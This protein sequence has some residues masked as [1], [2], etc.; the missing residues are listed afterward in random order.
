MNNEPIRV[1]SLEAIS[2]L[3]HEPVENL[4]EF[5]WFVQFG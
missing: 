5:K 3:T 2:K 1:D 4:L